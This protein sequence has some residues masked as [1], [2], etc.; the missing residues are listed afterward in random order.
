MN[1]RKFRQHPLNFFWHDER[2]ESVK[3]DEISSYH[4][5]RWEF[6]AYAR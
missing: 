1:I 6:D 2:A 5:Y 4:C 3:A